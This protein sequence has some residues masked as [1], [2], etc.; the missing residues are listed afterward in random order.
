M[1]VDKIPFPIAKKISNL[2]WNKAN[3]M[4]PIQIPGYAVSEYLLL[5]NPDTVLSEKILKL[6][7]AFAARYGLPPARGLRPHV[8]LVRFAAL[9]IMEEKIIQRLQ[10][11]TMGVTPFKVELRDFG[12]Y[13]T[14][15]LFV[16]VTT[17]LP[18][19]QLV[20][21]LKEAQ[22]LMKLSPDHKPH[23]FEDPHITIAQKLKP[24]QYEG[25]WLE[26]SHRQF[27]GRFIADGMLL[28]RRAQGDRRPYQVVRR[29][30]FQNQPIV[31]RQ[32]SL[33]A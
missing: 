10:V 25:G 8:P 19:Q 1:A 24:W 17:R 11:I 5:L 27:T 6:R 12:S 3:H 16:Q 33:F 32:G 9:Q 14:H 21:S 29:F 26:Y 15:S 31:T 13:P 23:F 30:E 18:I 7:Q 4:E 20:R 28:L 2:V 22:R